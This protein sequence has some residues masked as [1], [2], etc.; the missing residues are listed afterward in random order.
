[1]GSGGCGGRGGSG[2]PPRPGCGCGGCARRRGSRI[3][4]SRNALE[5]CSTRVFSSASARATA[6][7]SCSDFPPLAARARR[8]SFH[9]ATTI[10]FC[11][12]TSSSMPLWLPPGMLPFWLCAGAHVVGDNVAGLDVEVLEKQRVL[13]GDVD[14]G[15]RNAQRHHL[16][17]V[18]HR[19]DQL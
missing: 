2:G 10:S 9:V 14:A 6:L 4:P 12:V 17:D 1:G 11:A 5:V 15:P 3:A 19:V 18:L 7:M 13:A 8:S 16:L